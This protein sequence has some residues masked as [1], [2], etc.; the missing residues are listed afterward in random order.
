MSL[1]FF[2]FFFCI[3]NILTSCKSSLYT[4]SIGFVEDKRFFVNEKL[5]SI[6]ADWNNMLKEN[7]LNSKLNSF[8]IRMDTDIQN[9]KKYYYLIGKSTSD[10]VKVATILKFKK[11][12]F[13]FNNETNKIVICHGCSNSYPKFESGKWGWTCESPDL[14][15]DCG[16][17]SIVKF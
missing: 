15:T 5:D 14:N 2:F 16:K 4:N 9:S 12:K 6:Q 1:R 11:G 3:I 7:H 10:S 8:E 17:I 13:Y